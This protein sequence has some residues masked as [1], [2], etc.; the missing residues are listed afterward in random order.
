MMGIWTV[1][2]YHIPGISAMSNAGAKAWLGRAVRLTA[3]QAV[4]PDGHCNNPTYTTDLVS[5]D[6]Y[7]ASEFNLPPG[8][9]TPLASLENITVFQ[10][11][12]GHE[13]WTAMGGRMIRIDKDRSLAF[14]NG[15]FFELARDRDFRAVG[16]EPF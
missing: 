7:L 6:R 10:V 2:G 13:H 4:S 3:K 9:L 16:Q 14:W 11:Y 1:T 12:C 15:V 5:K 8:S